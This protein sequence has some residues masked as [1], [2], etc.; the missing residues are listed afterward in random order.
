M[1]KKIFGKITKKNLIDEEFGIFEISFEEDFFFKEGQFVNL[2]LDIKNQ[3][4]RRAYSIS[5][6]YD[7]NKKNRIEL[8]IKKV[9]EGIMTTHLF[10]KANILDEIFVMGPLGL[11][12]NDKI[13]K[14]EIIFIASST[15]IAP[16]RAMIKSFLLNKDNSKKKVKLFFANKTKK[17]VLY[18]DEFKELESKFSN[19]KFFPI[20]SREDKLEEGFF[21]GHVQ[22]YLNE[23]NIDSNF[24]ICGGVLMCKDIKEKLVEMGIE[25]KNI[26]IEA[27]N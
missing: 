3:K 4:I 7:K 19:F 23:M 27:Y 21:K 22:D 20:I 12:T 17:K 26:K 14:N 2:F 10:E 25:N 18:L 9:E 6:S 13:E 16:F 24:F 8:C 15:G 1:I 5:D 11:M